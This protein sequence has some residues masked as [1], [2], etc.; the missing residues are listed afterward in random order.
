MVNG[1]LIRIEK[2][3]VHATPSAVDRNTHLGIVLMVFATIFFSFQDGV[4]K[5]LIDHY[6]I[7]QLVFIRFCVLLVSVTL[8]SCFVRGPMRML[9]S[10]QVQLHL[11]R[12]VVLISEIAL[13]GLSFKYLGLAEAMTIF[14]SFPVIGVVLAFVFLKEQV[15]RSTVLALLAGVSG[16]IIASI[17]F[18]SINLVGMLCAL[19]A[20]VSYAAYI[21]LTRFTANDDG[22]LTSIFYVCLVGMALPMVFASHRF[23]AIE[24]KDVW[25]FFLLC[26]FNI[27]AQSAVIFAL[28]YSRASLLQPINYLQIVWAVFV[29]FFVFAEVPSVNLIL[30]SVLIVGAGLMLIAAN[31]KRETQSTTL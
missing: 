9:Q 17:P 21:V 7:W 5:S 4:T 30:G 24:A 8:V 14:H 27:I 1:R 18:G 2:T 3:N 20:A 26:L 25:L 13:L 6:P 23:V 11:V 16:L 12:G 19:G 22:P 31:R 15:A 28:S 29:G 10:K